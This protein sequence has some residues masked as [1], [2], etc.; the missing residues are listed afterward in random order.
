[1]F[2]SLDDKCKPCIFLGYGLEVFGYKIYDPMNKKVIR[3][4]DV[5]FLEDQTLQYLKGKYII[6]KGYKDKS[7]L[8]A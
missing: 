5:I 2:I 8:E 4:R 3:S 7:N 1:M 6:R